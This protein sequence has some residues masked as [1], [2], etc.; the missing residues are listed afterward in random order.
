MAAATPE[1]QQLMIQKLGELNPEFAQAPPD[2][3]QR[4]IQAFTSGDPREA[5][6]QMDAL[7][8]EYPQY[9]KTESIWKNKAFLIGLGALTAGVASAAIPAMMGG[10]AAAG[11]GAAAAGEAGILPSTATV[12]AT[13]ALAPG[14]TSAMAAGDAAG[15][16]TAGGAGTAAGA[17]G[18]ILGG[19]K[20]IAGKV[21]P[22]LDKLGPVLGNMAKAGAEANANRDRILPSMEAAQLARDKF[23]LD[24][25]GTRMS[26]SLEASILKNAQ[27]SNVNWA[28]PGSGARGQ[29]PTFTGGFTGALAN[30]DPETRQLADTVLHK[31]L[32]DQLA[33]GDDATKWLDQF[34]HESAMDKIIGGASTG[35]N[36]WDALRHPKPV[37]MS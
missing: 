17:G 18:S 30:L 14:A 16:F 4:L 8:K 6:R 23:A 31:D 3:K 25:P 15:M 12:G 37:V 11:G 9:V 35:V 20:G 2:L 5:V 36:I 19:I 21:S 28:G 22:Y 34:G 10:S 13:G 29:V 7:H 24:A 32:Q 33:G 1:Q 26:Q 27:P